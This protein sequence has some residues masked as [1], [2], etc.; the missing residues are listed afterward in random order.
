MVLMMK[1][2]KKLPP[3]AVTMYPTT[4]LVTVPPTNPPIFFKL[5]TAPFG[6]RRTPSL[7]LARTAR[8]CHSTAGGERGQPPQY[9]GIHSRG[10]FR[11][12][13]RDPHPDTACN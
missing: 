8:S 9:P 13:S 7:Y 5:K 12:E 6:T 11:I 2:V 10:T 1:A 4:T 3:S